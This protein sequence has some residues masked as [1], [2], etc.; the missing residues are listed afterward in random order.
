MKVQLI[1]NQYV[2]PNF[3]AQ[4]FVD[5]AI[6]NISPKMLNEWKSKAKSI[7]TD[8]DSIILYFGK[9]EIKK[10]SK[11]VLGLIPVETIFKSRT[12]YALA[13]INDAAVDENLSY[14][15]KK[16]KFDEKKYLSEV[17]NNYLNKLLG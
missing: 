12:I 3:K 15:M 9:Q 13:N 7:G 14:T 17:V 6:S 10:L 5:G 1:D 2:R 11:L 16:S 8:S 4:I